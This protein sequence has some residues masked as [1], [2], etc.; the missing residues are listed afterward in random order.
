MFAVEMGKGLRYPSEQL[1]KLAL[2]ALLHDVGMCFIPQGLW[3]NKTKL[4]SREMALIHRH[5][6]H[7]YQIIKSHLGD[8]FEWL[9]EGVR[10]EHERENG[11]GYPRGLS[12]DAIDEM[13]KIIGVCDVYEA[14]IYG[15]PPMPPYKAVKQII[16]EREG[17]FSMRILKGMLHRLPVFPLDSLVRLSTRAI[18]RVIETHEDQILRPTVQ[19]VCDPTKKHAD[20]CQIISLRE[21]RI[22]QI[23]DP[24]DEAELKS[25]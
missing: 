25:A 22:L 11:S 19:I 21:N 14:L 20:K 23:V 1:K 8:E 4:T 9:A 6:D 7:G 10:Q 18:A 15:R 5:P 13:A 2:G 17:L 24:V 16:H 3:H 12:G